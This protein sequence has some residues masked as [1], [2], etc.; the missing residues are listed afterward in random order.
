MKV[1]AMTLFPFRHIG[2]VLLLLVASAGL[3]RGEWVETWA[4]P[5][6]PDQSWT[7]LGLSDAVTSGFTNGIVSP[8]VYELAV[9]GPVGAAPTGGAAAVAGWVTDS[10]SDATGGLRVQA[11]INPNAVAQS[12]NI[13]VL[14][15]LDPNTLSGY[16]LTMNF[17]PGTLDIASIVGGA[18]TVLA[19]AN[20][21]GTWPSTSTFT[22][23][24]VIANGA[25]TGRVYDSL[26][27]PPLLEIS[28]SDTS[29]SSGLAGILA[30]RALTTPTLNGTYGTVTAAVPEPSGVVLAVMGITVLGCLAR[31]RLRQ[32]Q[33]NRGGGSDITQFDAE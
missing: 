15:Y 16:S 14:G 25:L 12:E 27:N 29:F 31:M 32:S 33:T 8:G 13:G 11:V 2:V 28:A 6:N 18:D 3:A 23:D 24:F 9:A 30:Q 1:A 7:F 4:G 19:S 10:F 20:I 26:S 5:T 17:T 22:L 21:P